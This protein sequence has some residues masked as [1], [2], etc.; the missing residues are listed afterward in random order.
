MADGVTHHWIRVSDKDLAYI[1]D[2]P[3]DDVD[4]DDWLDEVIDIVEDGLE[5]A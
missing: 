5:T 1:L 2:G 3:D 4:I